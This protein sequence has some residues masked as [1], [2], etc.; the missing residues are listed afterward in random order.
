MYREIIYKYAITN[1]NLRE[2]KSLESKIITVIPKGSPMEVIDAEEDWYKVKYNDEEG[3]VYNENI[4]KTL[5]T[6]ATVNFR[7]TPSSLGK[8]IEILPRKSRV[9]LIGKESDWDKV[10]YNGTEGYIYSYYLSDDGNKYDKIDY[11]DFYNDMTKF[12]NDMRITSS[13]NYLLV[14]DIA[15]RLTY[16]FKKVDNKWEE[17]YKWPCTVGKPSTPTITGTFFIAGRKPGFGTD[18]YSVKYATRIRGPYYYHSIL[19]NPEGTK[20]INGTLGE[21]LSHGCIRLATK[22]AQWIYDN[23]PDGTTVFIH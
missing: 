7:E 21:A 15:N 6:W 3:Y 10:I 1:V 8:T 18:K 2:G 16:V 20:V 12:V 5:Y 4:S 9:E 11:T 19:Y 13:S 14:T 17:L 22:N 23:I